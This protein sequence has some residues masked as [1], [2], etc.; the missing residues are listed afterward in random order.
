MNTYRI[1]VKMR[2]SGTD[3]DLRF[4]SDEVKA[5]HATSDII[6]GLLRQIDA[7]YVTGGLQAEELQRLNEQGEWVTC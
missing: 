4:Y 3:A 7:T 2:V 6:W 1:V 5:P